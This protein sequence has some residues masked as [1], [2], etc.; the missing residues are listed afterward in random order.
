MVDFSYAVVFV[1]PSTAKPISISK[2]LFVVL[3]KSDKERRSTFAHEEKL[4]ASVYLPFRQFRHSISILKYKPRRK[5]AFIFRFVQ[6]TKIIQ[7]LP[8]GHFSLVTGT[9]FTLYF[10]LHCQ[11]V[12]IWLLK[13]KCLARR[14]ELPRTKH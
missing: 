6:K 2:Y 10:A 7:S 3:I 11:Q 1:S 14:A 13:L 9:G 4:L 8:R 5:P 12:K